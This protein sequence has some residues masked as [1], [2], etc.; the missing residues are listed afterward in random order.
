MYMKNH[1]IVKK[2]TLALISKQRHGLNSHTAGCRDN[3]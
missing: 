1:K 3:H 2:A